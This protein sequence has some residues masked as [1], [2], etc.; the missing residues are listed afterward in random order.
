MV[1]CTQNTFWGQNAFCREKVSDSVVVEILHRWKVGVRN[2][3]FRFDK[4]ED[5]WYIKDS[6][7]KKLFGIIS[8]CIGLFRSDKKLSGESLLHTCCINRRLRITIEF[9]TWE[10]PIMF[11]EHTNVFYLLNWVNIMDFYEFFFLCLR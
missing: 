8:S 11:D 4:H 2:P 9:N 6:D 3:T 5:L 7:V 1:I 10:F